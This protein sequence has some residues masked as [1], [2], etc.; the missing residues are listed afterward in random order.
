MRCA[1]TNGS[2]ASQSRIRL[3][4]AMMT[5]K[6]D[7]LS[8]FALRCNWRNVSR[9]A[10][11]IVRRKHDEAA[12]GQPRREPAVVAEHV[13]LRVL[14][15]DIHGQSFQAVLA[16]NDWPAFARLE[17]FGYEQNAPG[18]D[19]RIDVQH[20]FVAG[21]ALC[22]GG[23]PPDAEAGCSEGWLADGN[24]K[25]RERALIGRA[26]DGSR[27]MT[28]SQRI[29]LKGAQ[30]VS[31]SCGELALT[32]FQKN[33]ARRAL[34][35]AQQLLRVIFQFLDLPLLARGGIECRTQVGEAWAGAGE[36]PAPLWADGLSSGTRRQARSGK[37]SAPGPSP[38]RWSCP[39]C[40]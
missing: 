15:D 38:V 29:C 4:C 31:Q 14:V 18:K 11:G 17:V 9:A 21:P 12:L 13:A 30:E 2:V 23:L 20:H 37:R 19:V 40:R 3:C 26:G 34:R 28:S 27:P 1:S 8:G 25:R 6:R 22:A 36:T 24:S 7:S 35:L 16:N 5:E 33:S 10:V 39:R 32:L